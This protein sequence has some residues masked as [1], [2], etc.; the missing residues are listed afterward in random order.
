MR[1]ILLIK[2]FFAV[3]E[4]FFLGKFLSDL[5]SFRSTGLV[6]SV[7]SIF[8]RKWYSVLLD[9]TILQKKR[10]EILYGESQHYAG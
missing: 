2:F 5:H 6:H 9:N 8:G 1:F 3:E 4:M 10:K 7:N